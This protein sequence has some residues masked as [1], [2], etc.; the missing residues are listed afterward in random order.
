MTQEK[1]TDIGMAFMGRKV[2]LRVCSLLS[3]PWERR[4]GWISKFLLSGSRVPAA[5]IYI[6]VCIGVHPPVSFFEAPI[7]TLMGV[8]DRR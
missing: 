3:I 7:G 4:Q 2:L 8:M 1:G 5:Y 6:S